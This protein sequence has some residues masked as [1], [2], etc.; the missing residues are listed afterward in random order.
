MKLE[1]AF[2]TFKQNLKELLIQSQNTNFQN[3][4]GTRT[5]LNC[6][7]TSGRFGYNVSSDKSYKYALD[8]KGDFNLDG[9]FNGVE[10]SDFSRT[11]KISQ[12]IDVICNRV[13]SIPYTGSF[14]NR[15][16]ILLNGT[17]EVQLSKTDGYLYN[18]SHDCIDIKCGTNSIGTTFSKSGKITDH[19]TGTYIIQ[20]Y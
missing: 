7:Y 6:E 14:P 8:V 13:L 9:K 2:K 5:I 18:I 12:S 19:T 16:R 3:T 20:I 1:A 10:I 11:P 17:T 15:I 4:E